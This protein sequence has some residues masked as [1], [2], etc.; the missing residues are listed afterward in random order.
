MARGEVPSHVDLDLAVDLIEGPL[1]VHLFVHQL[2][3]DGGQ[4]ERLIDLAVA[5]LVHAPPPPAT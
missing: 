2:P 3:L 4:I 5:G 1:F